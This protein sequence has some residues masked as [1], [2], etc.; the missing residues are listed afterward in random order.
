MKILSRKPTNKYKSARS[1]RSNARRTNVMNVKT[2][3]MRG[4]IRL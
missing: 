2:R 3:P 4:G 1:F